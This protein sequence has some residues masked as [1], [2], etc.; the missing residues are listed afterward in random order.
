MGIEYRSFGVTAVMANDE[1]KITGLAAPFN[2]PAQIGDSPWGFR[3]K[4]APGAFTKT[5][6]EADVVLLYNHDTG[7][8]L[9]RKSAGTLQLHE[10][11]RGLEIEAQTPE[12]T[13]AMDALKDIKAGNIRGM[14]FGFEPVKEDWFDD[15]GNPADKYTGTQRVLKEVKLFEVSACT[16]PAYD[17]TDISARDLVSAARDTQGRSPGAVKRKAKKEAKRA[18]RARIVD[19]IRAGLSEEQR[20]SIPYADPKNQKYP[21]DTKAHCQAA[22]AYINMPKNAAQYPLNGVTLADVKAKIMAA[23][24]AFGITINDQNEA[25][26]AMEW[27]KAIIRDVPTGM[28][29]GT[30][31]RIP[32]IAVLLNQALS[33]FSGAK[34]DS[35]PEDAQRAIAMVSSAATHANHIKEHEGLTTSDAVSA[36]DGKNRDA[37]QPAE[38]TADSPPNDDALRSA[39]AA[40][41]SREN[42]L[43]I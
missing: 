32:Q 40:A 16:F 18:R 12:T 39:W 23:C 11:D 35:L 28:K 30:A 22:W 6:S 37:S 43:G 14:S 25:I 26:L 17:T 34:I 27:R 36:N 4:I 3:E 41:L 38:T 29:A 24:K 15:D 8:P 9:A 7:K 33:L 20:D 42:E 21:I 5:I 31:K 1:G 2:S 19:E 13:H 10:S